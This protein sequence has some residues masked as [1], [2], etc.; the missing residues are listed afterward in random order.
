MPK[1]IAFNEDE[2]L[3]K[4]VDLFW[5]KGYNGTSM[6]DLTA[7]TGLN[8]SS[9][10]N[11]YNSKIELYE[12][13][14]KVYQKKTERLY[15]KA[16]LGSNN[17]KEALQLVFAYVIEEILEDSES[18]GCFNTNSIIEMSQ[19]NDSIKRL[20]E[21]TQ[22]NS[23]HFFEGL[24]LDSQKKGLVNKN[25]SAINYAQ[26]LINALQGLRVTGIFLKNPVTLKNISTSI[27][28]VF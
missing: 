7:M 3:K 18:K 6:Q 12:L 22:E 9:I 21:Q 25:D 8:R 4:V 17:S 19:K 24:I 2:V 20:L 26:Y 11:T 10:Y 14:L 27:F 28:K 1:E 23:I 15:Q 5:K 13:A 16:L